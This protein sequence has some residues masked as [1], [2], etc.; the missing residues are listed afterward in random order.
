MSF[1]WRQARIAFKGRPAEDEARGSVALAAFSHS[2][3][4]CVW[5]AVDGADLAVFCNNHPAL[6]QINLRGPQ[7]RQRIGGLSRLRHQYG[8]GHL[9]AGGPCRLDDWG[10]APLTGDQRRDLLEVVDDRH[11]RG[12]TI[13]TST[14]SST[15]PTAPSSE[16]A[17]ERSPPDAPILTQSRKPD[18]TPHAGNDTPSAFVGTGG[19]LRSERMAAFNRN[20]RPQSLQFALSFF[21]KATIIFIE[22]VR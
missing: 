10:L 16:T 9:R 13:I 3:A 12:S 7:R 1:L 5:D 17:C 20:P 11:Q 2:L 6:V 4:P 19:R 14:A 22:H 15:T 8:Q 18:P 21:P